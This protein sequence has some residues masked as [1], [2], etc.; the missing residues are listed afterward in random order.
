MENSKHI[1][2]LIGPSL[3]AITISEALN[4]HIWAANIA[5][6]IHLNGTLL[7][8]AGLSI[9]RAHN[10]WI[11]GWPVI[12]TLVGWF[13]IL[14]GLL[15]MFVPELYLQSVQNASAGMLIASIMIVCVIG[16]YLTFK[17]YGRED[18]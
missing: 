2:G 3:I 8:V 10:H 17:A 18:S 6:A 5:P 7:F 11:R 14:A 15:R 4:V 16:I 12:V 13:A 1:A 9:V